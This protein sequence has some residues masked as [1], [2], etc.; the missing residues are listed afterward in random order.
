MALIAETSICLRYF[1][2]DLIPDA[3]TSALGK[4]PTKSTTKGEMITNKTTGSVR[5]AKSGSWLYSVERREPGDL[6]GQ[7][8]E[9]FNALTADLSVWRALAAKYKPDLFVGLFMKE[10]YE[11][12]EISAECLDILSS[13]GVSFGFCIYGPRVTQASVR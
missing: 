5:V 7:I 11:G 4:A 12:I 9:L 8:K 10:S 3:L 2:D 6:D 1:G 13:R